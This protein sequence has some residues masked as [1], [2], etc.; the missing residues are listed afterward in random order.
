[1]GLRD[2]LRRRAMRPDDA[3]QPMAPFYVTFDS[4]GANF[5]T[6][7]ADLALLRAGQGQRSTQEQYLVLDMLTEQGVAHTIANGF[8]MRSIDVTRLDEDEA[9]ILGL[10]P[11]LPGRLVAHVEGNTTSSR[12]SVSLSADLGGV[13]PLP[14]ERTGPIVAVGSQKYRLSARALQVLRATE[15]HQ[16][17]TADQRTEEANVRLVADIQAAQ[18][19]AA[20]EDGVD[21]SLAHLDKFRT[22][23]PSSVGLLVSEAPDGGL[24]LAPD[25]GPGV[26]PELLRSRWHHVA[27]AQ[28][29]GVIRVDNQL[30]L[31]EERQLRGV[32]EVLSKPHIPREHVQDFLRSPA[33]YVDASVVDVEINFGVR[34]AGV[35]VI[36]PQT[37]ADASESGISWFGEASGVQAAEALAGLIAT[38][39]ELDRVERDIEIARESGRDTISVGDVLVDVGDPDAT[40]EALETVRRRLETSRGTTESA[41]TTARTVQIGVHLTD[42]DDVAERLARVAAEPPRPGPIDYG[43]LLRSPYPH[44]REGIEWLTGLLSAAVAGDENDPARV[45]GALLADDMGLGKTYMTLVALRE[46]MVAG[47]RLGG[48]PRPCLA[49]LPVALIENWES[50]IQE[51]FA[52]SPFD[53]VVVLQA[54]RDLPRFRL[55]GARRETQAHAAM[56]DEHGMLD[57]EKIRLSLRV[58]EPYGDA[59]LDT[60]GRLVLTTYETLASYQLSFAQVDWGVVV[61]DEAQTIKNPDSLRS[62]AAKALKA[63]FKL[64]A[65]GTPI[66]NSMLDFWSLMDT[67]QPGLLGSWADFRTTWVAR[68]DAAP[69]DE[70]EAVGNELRKLVGAFMLRRNKEDHLTDLPPKTVYGPFGGPQQAQRPDLGV[71]M[72][73]AQ[74]EKYDD[75]L[76]RFRTMGGGPGAAL[77]T[78]QA[79]RLVSLHPGAE[80]E[81]PLSADPAAA[82]LSARMIATL[83]VLDEIRDRDEKAIVFVIS[84]KVQ[85]RLASWLT[86]RYGLAVHVVNGD[87]SAVS[88]GSGE[89]R[90]G[91]IKDFES[92]PGFNVII[93]SPL[94]VGV[95]LTVVGA[96]HAIHLERHW[97]PAKEAQAT[98]RIYRIGQKRPVHIY[99]PMALHPDLESFDSNLDRLLQNKTTLRHAVV[100]PEAVSEEEMLG[101]LG[102]GDVVTAER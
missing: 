81:A 64:L 39:P 99:L 68:M 37:F 79:L 98:D 55:Q 95:G 53:D 21:F 27:A 44:Q 82:T 49:V 22:T 61:F 18:A 76:K 58:G 16:S 65:T 28:D 24:A 70:R 102:V 52:T 78:L 88:T 46:H 83:R 73:P 59:R 41:D 36:V 90:R 7:A 43:A 26:D 1:M 101:A 13:A 30:V 71:V 25:L 69:P 75:V 47:R 54:G 60:P 62:R 33:S 31:L 10:P 23:E 34:V 94:A 51:T 48:Q 4:E 3:D 32:R 57:V 92:K 85:R 91:L 84:K 80:G 20:P 19:G 86:D 67:A 50:E 96:N 63:Q 8:A 72:P 9:E 6:S 97:N 100:V 29:R 15:H 87:T 11:R 14:I 89:T 66:E 74:R 5:V 12:F 42:A 93:M 38:L 77:K 35:G 2:L 56:L 17:L 45:Q 40:T